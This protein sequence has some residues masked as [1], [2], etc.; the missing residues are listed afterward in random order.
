[1]DGPELGEHGGLRP[2]RRVLI[3]NRG[4]I[5]ERIIR[6]CKKMAIETVAVYSESDRDAPY[7]SLADQA[8]FIGPSPPRASYLNVEAL[9]EVA[10]AFQVDAIHPGYG[11][12]SENA[13]FAARCEKEGLNFIGPSS[14]CIASMGS[15]KAAKELLSANDPSIPL[16]PGYNG[17][18]QDPAFLIDQCCQIGFP[19]L[20]KASAGGGGKGMRIVRHKEDLQDSIAAAKREALNSFG[21]DTLLVERYFDNVRHV[22]FQILGDCHGDVVHCFER[23]C[24]LQRRHQKVIEETPCLL[25]SS[26]PRLREAMGAAAS[27]IG[28]I[29]GYQGA[30]TVEFILDPTTQKF[31]FLEVNTRLQVEHPITEAITG[32]DLVEMQIKLAMGHALRQL[33]LFHAKN[34]EGL[35]IR[36]HAIECRLYAEDPANSFFPCTGRLLAWRPCT[37]LPPESIRY[38]SGVKTGSEISIY[39]DPMICKVISYGANREEAIRILRKALKETVVMG[40]QTNKAFLLRCLDHPKFKEG[41]FTTHFIEQHLDELLK[42]TP[43]E[44]ERRQRRTNGIEG[45]RNGVPHFAHLVAEKEVGIAATVWDWYQ[46]NHPAKIRLLR[47]IPSGWRNSPYRYQSQRFVLRQYNNKQEAEEG[48]EEVEVKYRYVPTRSRPRGVE[49]SVG[50]KTVH[51]FLVRATVSRSSKKTKKQKTKPQQLGDDMNRTKDDLEVVLYRCDKEATEISINGARR[52]WMIISREKE[53]VEEQ[54][55]EEERNEIFLHCPIFGEREW[56]L[57]KRS[58]LGA[59]SDAVSEEGGYTAPMPGQIKQVLCQ[60]GARL[61]KGQPVL[62][63]ESMKMES[64]VCA[65]REGT[66][67]LF[68]KEGQTV[69]AGTVLLSVDDSAAAN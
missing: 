15:K 44:E 42:P 12:L 67:K 25:L 56:F 48:N 40:L 41:D 2:I 6:T 16:I 65:Q 5:A 9:M 28:A 68:V 13:E 47:H 34:G 58:R 24:S 60:D 27:S 36:G 31:Y 23:E 55:E 50:D 11:F 32:L 54:G 17:D 59:R 29:L 52:R 64:K 26:S 14:Q 8:A 66:L 39:Y 20:L 51:K 19:V 63:M 69:E 30:G 18:N 21:D 4:E 7:C 61:K 37:S 45:E 1:M 62:I 57:E 22:E 10:R 43:S 38:D 3:A 53:G 49:P 46:R 35:R 33:G